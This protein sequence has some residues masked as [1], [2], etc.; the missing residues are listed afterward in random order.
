MQQLPH[1]TGQFLCQRYG[2][3]HTSALWH[4]ITGSRSPSSHGEDVGRLPLIKDC[5]DQHVNLHKSRFVI[6]LQESNARGAVHAACCAAYCA[7][8]EALHLRSALLVAAVTPMRFWQPTQICHNNCLQQCMK[9]CAC[10]LLCCLL[11]CC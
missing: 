8:T 6:F 10:C 11:C 3:Y 2:R 4:F 1:E 5:F 9:C 7:V